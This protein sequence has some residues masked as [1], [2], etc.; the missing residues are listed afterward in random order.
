MAENTRN[1]Q[2]ELD[3]VIA[4]LDCIPRLVLHS[5][6]AP[7]SSYVLMYLS[8]F[9]DIGVIYFNPNIAPRAEYE[10]R[11]DEQIRFIHEA[12]FPHTVS[13]IDSAYEP[14]RFDAFAERLS[15]AP[16]CGERCVRCYELRLR[17]A[18][19]A[20]LTLGAQYFATTLTL[21]PHKPAAVINEIGE[22]ISR[23]VGVAYLPS[24]FKK[25]G[26]YQRSIELSR[27]FSLYRQNYC[28]CKYSRR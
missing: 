26:G 15:D 13:I 8:Q 22:R 1:Y 14:E 12:T 25:R 28:G 10:K 4:E 17:A 27:E 16:E 20:A 23:A 5:C 9:F 18:A 7:C 24:D 6:C 11:R 2:R 21:S 19:D 3:A